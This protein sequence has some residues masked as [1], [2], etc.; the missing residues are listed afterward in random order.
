MIGCTLNGEKGGSAE[1]ADLPR[2]Q[3]RRLL[4][5]FGKLKWDENFDYKAERRRA[6]P[7]SGCDRGSPVRQPKRG[8]I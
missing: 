3:Q 4:E 2:A 8:E 1:D 6:E 7:N 5:L